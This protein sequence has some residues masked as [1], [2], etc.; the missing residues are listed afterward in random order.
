MTFYLIF[1][2][3]LH[4]LR[5]MLGDDGDIVADG[6]VVLS[7]VA[8]VVLGGHPELAVL[9]VVCIYGILAIT[10]AFF[11]EAAHALVCLFFAI[12]GILVLTLR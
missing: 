11:H 5:I 7:L 9:V 10:H 1:I 8:L 3:L 4:C 12:W 6:V 2:I